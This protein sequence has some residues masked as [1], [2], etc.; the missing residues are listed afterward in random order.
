VRRAIW[1]GIAALLVF[2]VLL[3]ARFPARWAGAWLPAGVTC[4]RLAGTLWNG[5][6]AGLT[7][8]GS[9]IGD[10][11]WTLHPARLLAGR[12]GGDV[13]LT[14]AGLDVRGE[15]EATPRGNLVARNLQVLVPL[16]RAVVP[17]APPNLRGT[18]RAQLARL[19]A[20][21]RT[22]TQIEGRI[23]A[24]GLVQGAGAGGVTLGDYVVTFPAAPAAEEPVG[25]LQDLRGPLDV[26]GSLRLTREPG[27]VLEGLV[28]ARPDATPQL[29]RQLEYLGR[30]DAAGRR[31]FSIAGT[32]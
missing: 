12:L 3:V 9:L 21:G 19:A 17:Q 26:S 29:A 13:A 28:A 8:N 7:A 15:I 10:A 18:V 6:C 22:I 24:L 2:G 5:R 14:R 16:D 4:Q 1:M 27:F 25:A 11:R 32:F 23:E 30:P 31:P 20:S